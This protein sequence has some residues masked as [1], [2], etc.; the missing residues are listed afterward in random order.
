MYPPL[1]KKWGVKNFVW[2]TTLANFSPTIKTVAPPLVVPRSKQFSVRTRFAS[3]RR[4]FLIHF[5]R[6]FDHVTIVQRFV[7]F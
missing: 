3:L 7:A 5:L 4:P 1:V 6:T 2:L